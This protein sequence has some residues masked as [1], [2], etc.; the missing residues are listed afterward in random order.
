MITM[1]DWKKRGVS[2]IIVTVVSSMSA[3]TWFFNFI[4][5]NLLLLSNFVFFCTALKLPSSDRSCQAF[6]SKVRMGPVLEVSPQQKCFEEEVKEQ[7]CWIESYTVPPYRRTYSCKLSQKLSTSDALRTRV[8]RSLALG[9]FLCDFVWTMF[10]NKE[11]KI[12]QF[13][14]SDALWQFPLLIPDTFI[15]ILFYF[16]AVLRKKLAEAVQKASHAMWKVKE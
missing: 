13:Q 5:H 4:L 12:T 7:T 10:Q 3:L 2:R 14:F 6:R 9:S 8:F 1:F 15:D 16:K 11:D